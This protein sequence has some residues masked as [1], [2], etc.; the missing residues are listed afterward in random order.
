MAG[1][2][3]GVVVFVRVVAL[4]VL[5]KQAVADV[6]IEFSPDVETLAA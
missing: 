6:E 4:A 2:Y 5:E 1:D 3:F